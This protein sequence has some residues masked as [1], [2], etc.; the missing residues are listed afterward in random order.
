VAF[1]VDSGPVNNDLVTNVALQTIS[2]ELSANLQNGETIDI[3]FDNGVSWDTASGVAGSKLWTY[4][5]TALGGSGVM[6]IRVTDAAGN[7]GAA[8]SRSYVVDTTRPPP[9]APTWPT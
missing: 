1:S 6:Q 7:H 3:S 4:G 5:P 2:G 8:S 9:S